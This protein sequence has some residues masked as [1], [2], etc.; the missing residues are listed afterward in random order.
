MNKLEE[1]AL[2]ADLR[3]RG[4]RIVRVDTLTCSVDEYRAGA[5]R[6]GRREGWRIRTF[7]VAD[8]STVVVVWVDRPTTA[9]EDEAFRRTIGQAFSGGDAASAGTYD[10]MLE[11]V[12]R[13]N[14][15]VVR[16][17]T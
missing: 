11:Q 16:D 4:D 14:L 15:S 17:E 12:R 2:L 5:R 13:E 1:D 8:E 9:L 6:I 10:R 3:R 7:L